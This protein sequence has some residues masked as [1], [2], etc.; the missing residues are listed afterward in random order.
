LQET[1]TAA[2]TAEVLALADYNNSLAQLDFA[3]G[4][5]LERHKLAVELK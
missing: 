3:R 4:T 5:M 2:R 1:L